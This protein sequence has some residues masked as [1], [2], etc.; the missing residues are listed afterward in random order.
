MHFVRSQARNQLDEFGKAVGPV[1]FED[2]EGLIACKAVEWPPGTGRKPDFNHLPGIFP[3]PQ[4]IPVGKE[5][6]FFVLWITDI[7]P[8]GIQRAGWADFS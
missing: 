3:P 1:A 7:N 6:D 8:R 4:F 2:L 5:E